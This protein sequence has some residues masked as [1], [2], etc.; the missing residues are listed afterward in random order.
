M[1]KRLAVFLGSRMSLPSEHQMT[2]TCA[3]QRR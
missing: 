1:P 2:K 3:V